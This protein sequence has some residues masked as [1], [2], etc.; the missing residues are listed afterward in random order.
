MCKRK[1]NASSLQFWYILTILVFEK[2]RAIAY[3]IN[4]PKSYY[5][6]QFSHF[7]L[8]LSARTSGRLVFSPFLLGTTYYRKG[9]FP[10]DSSL[11][12][13][14]MKDCWHEPLDDDA[15]YCW[16]N[17]RFPFGFRPLC[18]AWVCVNRQG[19]L[20]R[21]VGGFFF[22]HAASRALSVA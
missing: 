3:D 4:L 10:T 16:H 6:K 14:E 21:Q 17:Q 22:W 15:C 11:R 8:M 12:S 20:P 18:V 5:S 13:T 1:L 2:Y 19:I 7:L 9:V